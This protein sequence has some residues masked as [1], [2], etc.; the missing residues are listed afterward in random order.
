FKATDVYL[1]SR[2][3]C[4]C[5]KELSWVQRE[6][7][8][9]RQGF[10]RVSEQNPIE[11]DPREIGAKVAT[12]RDYAIRVRARGSADS[13]VIGIGVGEGAESAPGH[14][15]PIPFR[16]RSNMRDQPLAAVY[17]LIRKGV[18][19][20]PKANG[21]PGLNFLAAG[22]GARK[23]GIRAHARH[24]SRVRRRTACHPLEPFP[25]ARASARSGPAVAV[26]RRLAPRQLGAGYRPS[27]D[28]AL[29]PGNRERRGSEVRPFA[30][31]QSLLTTADSAR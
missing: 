3:G 8:G 16:F 14:L 2:I 22:R 27:P 6:M 21:S 13:R 24:T 31:K 30:P 28:R 10:L 20:T 5:Y 15:D 29:D 12:R 17:L 11:R 19:V 25:V 23:S 9:S 26:G 1:L 18:D 7:R 4:E